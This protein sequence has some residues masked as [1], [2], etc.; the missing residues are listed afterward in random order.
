M[1]YTKAGNIGSPYPRNHREIKVRGQ[2]QENRV[3][4][5]IEGDA[6]AQICLPY[7]V[8]HTEEWRDIDLTIIC[9]ENL[10]DKQKYRIADYIGSM[11]DTSKRTFLAPL[12]FDLTSQCQDIHSVYL[13]VG[14]IQSYKGKRGYSFVNEEYAKQIEL[15]K[16]LKEEGSKQIIIYAKE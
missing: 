7:H 10:Q 9:E 8:Q 12:H 5:Q 14:S 11:W 13:E 2:V 4:L 6:L 16:L 3:S 1:R 15:P